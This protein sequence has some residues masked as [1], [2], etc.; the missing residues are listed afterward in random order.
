MSRARDLRRRYTP[1]MRE[2]RNALW[3]RKTRTV[4]R[5][6]RAR[7]MFRGLASGEFHRDSTEETQGDGTNRFGRAIHFLTFPTICK[8]RMEA[9]GRQPRDLRIPLVLGPSRLFGAARGGGKTD[10]LRAEVLGGGKP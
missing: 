2:R 4:L 10:A 1:E 5:T 7:E 8:W 9:E 6:T 3:W